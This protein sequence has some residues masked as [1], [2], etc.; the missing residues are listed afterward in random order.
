MCS[1][2]VIYIERNKITLVCA[3]ILLLVS[4]G[5]Y[6]LTYHRRHHWP[7]VFK[8]TTSEGNSTIPWLKQ[9]IAVRTNRLTSIHMCYQTRIRM[10]YRVTSQSLAKHPRL[11]LPFQKDHPW[12]QHCTQPWHHRP[13]PLHSK[14]N[15]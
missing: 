11:L 3:I 2:R 5:R 15:R 8:H 6:A 12:N 7:N 14:Q 4:I 10:H 13:Q 1:G 9:D